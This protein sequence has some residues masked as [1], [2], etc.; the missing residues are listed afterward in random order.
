LDIPLIEGRDFTHRDVTA[1]ERVAIVNRAMAQLYWP[2]ETPV[3][4]RLKLG[5]LESTTPWLIVVGVAENAR[6]FG[7]ESEPRREFYLP[8]SQSAWPVMTIVAKTVGDPM[9]WRSALK[10]VVK[11]VDPNLPVARISPMTAVIAGSVAPRETPMRL[12]TGFAAIGLLLASVGVYGVLAYFVSQRTREIGVRAALGA[13]RAQLAALVV[14]Q[15][16]PSIFAGVALGVAG[17]IAT[18]GMLVDLL[19]QVRPGD[20]EV[21]ASIVGLLVVAALLASWLP[22]RRAASIDPLVALRDE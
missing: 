3:G 13:T 22:A 9:S 12:L 1:G 21:I 2:G 10:G 19:Y 16:L 6:H 8:Y 4:K 17:S 11:R 15:S 7:L 5:S 20:P 18:G 14:R